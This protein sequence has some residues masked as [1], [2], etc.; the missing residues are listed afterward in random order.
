M[1]ALLYNYLSF[2]GD[3][4]CDLCGSVFHADCLDSSRP[5]PKCERKRRR[6]DVCE[7]LTETL[8]LEETPS[9]RQLEEAELQ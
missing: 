3:G 2:L 1:S 4:Q 9:Q 5:C 7:V 8:L 6:Y